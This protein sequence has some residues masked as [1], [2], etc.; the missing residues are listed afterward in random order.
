MCHLFSIV[1]HCNLSILRIKTSYTVRQ[2]NMHPFC[3][4]MV[5][6]SL[7]LYHWKFWRA[8]YFGGLTVLRAI[9]QYFIRQK[10]HSVM[11]SILQNHSLCTRPAVRCA[12]LIVGMEF[13]FESC[14]LLLQRVLCTEGEELARLSSAIKVI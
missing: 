9:R 3:S 10:L 6:L 13:T 2:K 11:S 7:L 12:S 14:T 5:L 8:I 1:Y 4:C